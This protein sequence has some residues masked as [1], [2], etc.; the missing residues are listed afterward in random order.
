[1]FG[2]NSLRTFSLKKGRERFL[3]SLFFYFKEKG[4]KKKNEF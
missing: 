2:D 1:M 4:G 3:S